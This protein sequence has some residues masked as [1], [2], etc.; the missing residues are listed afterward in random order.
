M[1]RKVDKLFTIRTYRYAPENTS[2]FFNG[3]ALNLDYQTKKEIGYI[4]ITKG[5]QKAHDVLLKYI[6]KN[7]MSPKIKSKMLKW[8]TSDGDYVWLNHYYGLVNPYNVREKLMVYKDLK[9]TL[10][11]NK[12]KEPISV[13]KAILDGNYQIVDV[14]HQTP[15]FKMARR[16]KI[17]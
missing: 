2:I 7:Y 6:R 8:R 3:K 15:T 12:Y 10:E 1:A 17:I 16:I 11:L 9:E 14:V 13:N 4:M 5:Y